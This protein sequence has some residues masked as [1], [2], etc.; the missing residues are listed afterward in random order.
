MRIEPNAEWYWFYEPKRR[1]LLLSI[2]C[3]N[4]FLSQYSLKELGCDRDIDTVPV[5][6]DDSSLFYVIIQHIADLP[7]VGFEKI[8]IALNS[9]TALKFYGGGCI[10]YVEN[11]KCVDQL[12][13]RGPKFAEVLSVISFKN[14]HEGNLQVRMIG[15]VIAL[16]P[17]EVQTLC[18]VLGTGLEDGDKSYNFMDLVTVDNDC[19][20]PFYK[21]NEEF[22]T[23]L[24]L[25]SIAL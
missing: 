6:V 1:K 4:L 9:I 19:L 7:Y 8:Q 16:K 13:S 3:G 17:G 24:Q 15:D 21:M 20:M 25:K 18:M 23:E 2:N 22:N 14:C 12:K 11:A 5:N 10:N